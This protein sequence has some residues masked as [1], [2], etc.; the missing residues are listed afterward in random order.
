[1]TWLPLVRICC[2]TWMTRNF[3]LFNKISVTS[4]MVLS[5]IDTPNWWDP[6]TLQ[7]QSELEGTGSTNHQSG[8]GTRQT[9]TL[10][11]SM[12]CVSPLWTCAKYTKSAVC[13]ASSHNIGRFWVWAFSRVWAQSWPP[14]QS[15]QILLH[16]GTFSAQVWR[17]ASPGVH[18]WEHQMFGVFS[19]Q[20]GLGWWV[21]FSP[22]RCG[23]ATDWKLRDVQFS[24]FV[25]F[26]TPQKGLVQRKYMNILALY[27]LHFPAARYWGWAFTKKCNF[28]VSLACDL[29]K[30]RW[31]WTTLF[32][33]FIFV[34]LADSWRIIQMNT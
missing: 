9:S 19:V 31:N 7:C 11:D 17:L 28:M 14:D 27:F 29:S 34:Y 25:S 4:V 30:L 33:F 13:L 1:M 21:K 15:Q 3:V 5:R 2:S 24:G 32:L 20:G 26:R 23:C 18:R 16:P 6:P 8:K 22:L 12:E 10:L